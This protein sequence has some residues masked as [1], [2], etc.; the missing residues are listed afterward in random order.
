MNKIDHMRVG[1]LIL[2]KGGHFMMGIILE[3]EPC[4]VEAILNIFWFDA[5]RTSFFFV[6][7][8]EKR[9]LETS[10]LHESWHLIRGHR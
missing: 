2:A 3:I 5:N 6:Q 9:T 8:Q 4:P 1:D 7:Y 10:D